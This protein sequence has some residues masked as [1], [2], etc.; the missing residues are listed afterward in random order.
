MLWN[1]SARGHAGAALIATACLQDSP[2]KQGAVFADHLRK[3]NNL[4]DDLDV[5]HFFGYGLSE[6]TD[7][8]VAAS[9]DT[10]TREMWKRRLDPLYGTLSFE[11]ELQALL[12]PIRRRLNTE[13]VTSPILSTLFGSLD[14]DNQGLQSLSFAALERAA[15]QP[16]V[17]P[18]AVYESPHILSRVGE[19]LSRG[20]QRHQLLSKDLS[21]ALFFDGPAR[22]GFQIGD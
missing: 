15:T 17:V 11:S 4:L 12:L 16:D 14:R 2:A 6:Q 9:L 3:S 18:L 10:Y 19:F 5:L 1:V 8:L 20:R 21:A 7:L 13:P 22:Y